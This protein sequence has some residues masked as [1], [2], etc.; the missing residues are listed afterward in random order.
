M[1]V[2]EGAIFEKMRYSVSQ[3][4]FCLVPLQNQPDVLFFMVFFV[5]VC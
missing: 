2:Y 5:M 3:K 1:Y 4:A